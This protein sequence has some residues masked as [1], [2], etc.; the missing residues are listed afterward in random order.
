LSGLVTISESDIISGLRMTSSKDKDMVE[1]NLL[2]SYNSRLLLWFFLVT[3]IVVSLFYLTAPV[4]FQS[5]EEAE[6]NAA[7]ARRQDAVLIQHFR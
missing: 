1:A 5:R 6:R 3:G 7:E 4:S 2:R